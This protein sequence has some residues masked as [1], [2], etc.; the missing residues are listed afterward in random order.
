M[1]VGSRRR[2]T[3]SNLTPLGM[4]NAGGGGPLTKSADHEGIACLSYSC[5]PS[6]L[7]VCPRLFG[8]HCLFGLQAGIEGIEE[9]VC[10]NRMGTEN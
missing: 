4:R 7:T 10:L 2:L 9:K 1:V 8:A 6:A 3:F 5:T